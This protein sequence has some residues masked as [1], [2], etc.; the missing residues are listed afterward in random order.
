MDLLLAIQKYCD[1]LIEYGVYP[2]NKKPSL[3]KLEKMADLCYAEKYRKLSRYIPED[4]EEEKKT[5]L[6]SLME[7]IK[8]IVKR[9][10]KGEPTNE[11]N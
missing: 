9:D 4:I 1:K 11:E 10:K 8:T 2:K 6:L 3:G 5:T 7:D